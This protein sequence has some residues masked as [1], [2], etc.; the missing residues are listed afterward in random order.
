[1]KTIIAALTLTAAMSA[2]AVEF[3]AQLLNVKCQISGN[4]VVRTQS[5]GK[6]FKGS[7]TEKKQVEFNG[8]E[9]LMNKVAEVSSET[10]R[11]QESE[12]VYT[13]IKDGKTL[14]LDTRDSYESMSLVQMIS[15]LCR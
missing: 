7:F 1:M 2:S 15:K 3:R 11:T 4:E 13:M 10:P 6:D 9:E 14:Y 5:F 12:Y 8:M